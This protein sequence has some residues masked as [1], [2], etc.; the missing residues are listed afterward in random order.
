MPEL[1]DVE[2]YRRYLDAKA[3]HHKIA[4]VEVESPTVLEETSPQ[5][6]GR[7]LKGKR[8]ESTR[9]HGKYLFAQLSRN[10]WLG[11]HFGMTGKLQYVKD[12]EAV[13]AY[14]RCLFKF[15]NGFDLAYIAPRKLGRIVPVHSVDEF[16]ESH[17]L[18]PDA[19]DLDV[20]GFLEL[21]RKRGGEVK[22]WLMNQSV[23]AGLGNVYS[24]EVLFQARV[25]PHC[26]V[27]SLDDKTLR[28][29]H[30]ATIKVLKA[31]IKSEA[32][33]SRMPKSFLLPHRRDGEHCPRCG[34]ELEKIKAA[35]RTAWLCPRC[36]GC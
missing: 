20:N 31:A 24:D 10:E 18:G 34:G 3:L 4:R 17:K 14:T 19:L 25:H 2:S 6:L 12:K 8:F 27:K 11:M 21:A 28:E 15:D 32:D 9:R 35:G 29:L 30:R 33:P 22:S 1:P 16:I 13:P 26:Q 7:I 23:M 36:Q 5:G